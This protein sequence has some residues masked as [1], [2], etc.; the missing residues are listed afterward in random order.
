MS[1]VIVMDM[2][3]MRT[4]MDLI[5]MMLI[6]IASRRIT[7]STIIRMRAMSIILKRAVRRRHI[8]IVT[9]LAL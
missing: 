9:K 3:D 2:M 4:V 6:L 1:I 8:V 7:I 5:V